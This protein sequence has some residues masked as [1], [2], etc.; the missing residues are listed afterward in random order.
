MADAQK[1]KKINKTF[2]KYFNLQNKIRIIILWFPLRIEQK[3]AVLTDFIFYTC[4][5]IITYKFKSN[6][7]LETLQIVVVVIV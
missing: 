6:Y 5:L 4:Q 1:K 7:T 2:Q 3:K